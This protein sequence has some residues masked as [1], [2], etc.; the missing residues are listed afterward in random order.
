MFEDRVGKK[1]KVVYK[2]D[3]DFKVLFGKLLKADEYFVDLELE[4]MTLFAVATSKITSIK[5]VGG[6]NYG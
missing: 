2:D 4:D 1:V 3:T 6:I 5:L